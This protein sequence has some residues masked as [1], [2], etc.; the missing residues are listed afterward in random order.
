MIN[1]KV[2]S[3]LEK[4]KKIRGFEKVKFIILYGSTATEHRRKTSDIDL[5][6]FYDGEPDEASKFRFRV[7]SELF[8]DIYDVQI[9]EHLPIYVQKE[10]LK[11]KILYSRDMKFLYDIAMKTI[12]QFEDFKYRFYD[13]IGERA[14]T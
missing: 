12:K 4:I 9:F 5:C 2:L 8:D 6:I 11:G 1:R 13:Y 10:V 7:L 14:I 3:A